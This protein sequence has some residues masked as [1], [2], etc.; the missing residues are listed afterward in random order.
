[1]ETAKRVFR[2]SL[3]KHGGKAMA[4]RPVFKATANEMVAGNAPRPRGAGVVDG[5]A[6]KPARASDVL[7]NGTTSWTTN[8]VA[9]AGRKY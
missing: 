5:K 4:G 2:D 3:E 6:V 8:K 9:S 7:R 1:M